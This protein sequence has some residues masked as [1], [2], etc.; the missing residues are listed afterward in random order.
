LR[1]AGYRGPILLFKG[2]QSESV[3]AA[4]FPLDVWPVSAE[5]E[6]LL[7]ELIDGY[8]TNTT[9]RRHTTTAS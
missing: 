3:S 1:A 4:R 2:S 9:R 5:D 8:A 6:A 7:V